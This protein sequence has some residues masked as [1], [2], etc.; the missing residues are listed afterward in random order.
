MIGVLITVIS[1][2][3][4]QLLITT[5]PPDYLLVFE[6]LFSWTYL[7]ALAVTFLLFGALLWFLKSS[8]QDI[9]RLI[10]KFL[11]REASSEK[12]T[13]P[14]ITQYKAKFLIEYLIQIAPA[15]S[16]KNN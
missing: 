1:I 6:F 4:T 7:V 16:K 10:E 13:T 2:S 15:Q 14:T 8:K 12:N 9:Y 11:N 5:H 3:L